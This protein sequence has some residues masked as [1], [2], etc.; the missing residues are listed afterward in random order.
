[1]IY[2]RYVRKKNQKKICQKCQ[3]KNLNDNFGGG[4]GGRGFDGR[5]R[6]VFGVMEYFLF[7]IEFG[8]YSCR[9]VMDLDI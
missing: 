1:M 4:C 3:E 6:R 9:D 2:C 5:G 8:L 7:F